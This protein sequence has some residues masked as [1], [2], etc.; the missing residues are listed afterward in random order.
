L[1]VAVLWGMI[2]AEAEAESSKNRAKAPHPLKG[3]YFFIVL[4]FMN[5]CIELYVMTIPFPIIFSTQ[6]ANK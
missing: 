3:K 1:V 6:K 5:D 2:W 4:K